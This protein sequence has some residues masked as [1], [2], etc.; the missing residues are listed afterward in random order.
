MKFKQGD[1]VKVVSAGTSAYWYANKIGEIYTLN[2]RDAEGDWSVEEGN[3]D[4]IAEEDIVL[5]KDIVVTTSQF[6]YIGLAYGAVIRDAE[7]VDDGNAYSF[8]LNGKNWYLYYS[9]CEVLSDVEV[10]SANTTNQP[11]TVKSDGG[12]SSYYEIEITNKHGES[13]MVEMGDIIRCA[14]NNDF[15]LGNQAKALRRIAQAMVGKGKEGVTI[16][17]DCNKIAYF[18]NEVKRVHGEV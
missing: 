7:V 17:Y 2:Y 8:K 10:Y 9:Q 5:V 11:T 3:Q 13:I 12:S 4:F 6:E 1:R 18:N 16:A 15:D 14:Y